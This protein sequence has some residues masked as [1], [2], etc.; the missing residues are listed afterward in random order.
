MDENEKTLSRNKDELEQNNNSLN[1]KEYEFNLN[2]DIYKLSIEIFSKPAIRFTLKQTNL[3]S[4]IYY[5]KEYEYQEIIRLMKMSSDLYNS[6]TKILDF[7][8]MAITKKIVN[9]E[10]EKPNGRMILKLTTEIFFQKI[11]TKI[12]L[13]ECKNKS[14]ELL[15][16]ILNEINNIKNNPQIN[17]QFNKLISQESEQQGII[18]LKEEIKKL[19]E[20]HDK[21][22]QETIKEKEEINKTIQNINNQISLQNQENN[23]LKK[24][25][26]N[27]N[28]DILRLIQENK[29]LKE[30]LDKISVIKDEMAN[31]ITKLKQENINIKQ[32]LGQ[33]KQKKEVTKTVINKKEPIEKENKE[34]QNK[35][36]IMPFV[37][38]PTNLTYKEDLSD[39]IRGYGLL[40]NFAVYNGLKDN[41]E[42]IVY[43][44]K[45]DYNLEIMRI[46]DKMIITSLKGHNNG[47]NVIRYYIKENKEDYIISS[48][49]NKLVIIW[50]IQN[51][52]QKKYI[53]QV[54]DFGNIWD[55]LI[56]F[57]IFNKDYIIL[58][59]SSIDEFTKLYEFRDKTPFIKNIYGTDKNITN[60]IIP[61]FY[62]KQYYIIEICHSKIS[63]NNILKEECYANFTIEK[64]G[65]Y[66]CGYIYNNK[67]LC[68]SDLNS[69]YIRIWDL[70]N[71]KM[72]KQIIYDGQKAREIKPWNDKY[73]IVGCE[74]G[75][76]IID[77]EKEVMVKKIT[78]DNILV[79][80]VKKMKGSKLTECLIISISDKSDNSYKI[81]LYN[82]SQIK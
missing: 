3:I 70:L 24:L 76:V 42:Y 81:K 79:E 49:K 54:K 50:D 82:L 17:N 78:M 40:N 13:I 28:K 64:E 80:G 5:Q 30:K 77:M 57:N 26:N 67:Y 74:G 52:Y 65:K 68:F 22:K 63:I 36:D 4:D 23:N 45:S 34:L 8:D 71:K 39:N 9:L 43:N 47:T 10:D 62:K 31:E 35:I 55:S 6:I 72:Y 69:N 21:E 33:E 11:E 58:P 7:W 44:K 14:A 27:I 48:D 19:K 2:N 25:I 20:N 61:W 66:C 29:T 75:L 59:S 56:L 41:L 46:N 1:L 12:E 18:Q 60:Y 16:T 15:E 32:Q 73:T 38:D 51:Q 53:I 37:G